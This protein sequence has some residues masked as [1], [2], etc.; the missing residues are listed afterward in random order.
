MATSNAL[1]YYHELVK[2]GI[3]DEQAFNQAMAFDNAI[4]N[5]AT[6]EDIQRIDTK[7]QD[8][9]TKEELKTEIARMDARFDKMDTRFDKMGIEMDTRFDKM[10]LRFDANFKLI[11]ANFATM[12]TFGWAIVVIVIV[13]ISKIVFGW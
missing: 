12:R 2:A 10:D 7:L 13:P 9:A 8:F 1:V 4:S 5:L 3:P 11:D 6:K